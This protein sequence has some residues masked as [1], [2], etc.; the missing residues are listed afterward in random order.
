MDPPPDLSF[1]SPLR[2]RK[3]EAARALLQ[4]AA[5]DGTRSQRAW[6]IM[7]DGQKSLR[8]LAAPARALGLGPADLQRLVDGGWIE[9]PRARASTGG[10]R[11]AAPPAQP[12][13]SAAPVAPAAV[14][15]P[16]AA[17]ASARPP[18]EAGPPRS[19]AVAK[20]YAIDLVRVLLPAHQRELVEL[21]R[22]VNDGDGLQAWLQVVAAELTARAGPERARLF[23]DKVSLV[24]PSPPAQSPGAGGPE[25]R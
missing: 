9:F 6:L 19:W 22:T 4:G 12:P 1:D 7:V 18:A 20:M 24:M 15:A 10:A 23:I 21:S 16:A 5:F 25:P 13:S 11:R 17:V 3:S 14:A 2:P 8:E